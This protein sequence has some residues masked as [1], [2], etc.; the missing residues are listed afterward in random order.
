MKLE[1]IDRKYLEEHAKL[2]ER[3]YKLKELTKEEFDRLHAELW[4]RHE[5]ELRKHGFLPPVERVWVYVLEKREKKAEDLPEVVLETRT[6]EAKRRLTKEE[7]T[8][9]EKFTGLK[10][11]E[12]RVEEREVV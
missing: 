1:D 10:I 8:K 4:R 9:L 7:K 5:E 2:E 3:Y 12:E 11:V 6:Y